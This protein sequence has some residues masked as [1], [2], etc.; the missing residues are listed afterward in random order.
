MTDAEAAI[1]LVDQMAMVLWRAREL[2]VQPRLRRMKPDEIDRQS[3][4]W[5]TMRQMA[6][7]CLCES[8]PQFRSLLNPTAD[9]VADP[10]EAVRAFTKAVLHGDDEHKAWLLEAAENFIAGKPLPAPRGKG[11]AALN[12]GVDAYR[13]HVESQFVDPGHEA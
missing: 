1:E 2:T 8:F 13:D 6:G 12:P 9:Y 5:N 11:T 4:A 7:V 10:E 3:G